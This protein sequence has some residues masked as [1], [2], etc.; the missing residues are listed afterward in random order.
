MKSS[1]DC[2]STL[3]VTPPLRANADINK[4]PK[5]QKEVLVGM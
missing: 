4:E 5:V 1:S 2:N 3:L